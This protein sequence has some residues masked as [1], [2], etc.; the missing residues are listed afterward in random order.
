MGS[1]GC[2]H[3]FWR[4]WMRNDLDVWIPEIHGAKMHDCFRGVKWACHD[5]VLTRKPKIGKISEGGWG[6]GGDIGKNT[7]FAKIVIVDL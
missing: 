6:G 7:L 3:E 2:Y 1:L 4:K 5:Q